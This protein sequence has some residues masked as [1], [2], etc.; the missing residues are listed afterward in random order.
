MAGLVVA[1]VAG[2][3]NDPDRE[4]GREMGRITPVEPPPFLNADVAQLFGQA[5]FSARVEVQ[6]GF[7]GSQPPMVGE[8]SGRDGNLFFI[9]DQQR[10]NRGFSGGLSALWDA[11]TQ[12]AYL[13]NEPLQ[14]YAPIRH[15]G[16]NGPTEITQA[17]EENIGAERCRKSILSRRNGADLIPVLVVWRGIAEQDLPLRIQTTNTPGAVTLNLSRIRPQAPPADL[18]A[19]PN[20]FKKFDSADAMLSELMRRRTDLIS[21]RNKRNRDKYGAPR[22]E[23]EAMPDKLDRPY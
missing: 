11:P 2:C 7:P 12:T 1:L 9:A 19:L 14:A 23:D 6:K 22:G 8:L 20:G 4:L 10:S 13:L 17:G 18:F 21:A 15:S 3:A 16:T 5:N